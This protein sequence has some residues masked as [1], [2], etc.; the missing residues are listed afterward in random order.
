[1]ETKTIDTLHLVWYGEV[2]KDLPITIDMALCIPITDPACTPSVPNYGMVIDSPEFYA[3]SKRINQVESGLSYNLI[4]HTDVEQKLIMALP[5]N[6][7]EGL[8]LAKA[9]RL[10]PLL[11]PEYA[12]DLTDD[13][14]DIHACLKTYFLKTSLFQLVESDNFTSKMYLSAEQWAYLIYSNLLTHLTCK[15]ELHVVGEFTTNDCRPQLFRCQHFRTLHMYSKEL[16]AHCCDSFNNVLS[17]VRNFHDVIA[18]YCLKQ[19]FKDTIAL[20]SM[21]SDG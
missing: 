3:F 13:V 11:K 2:Y 17:L 16:R 21:L 7:R 6:A 15:G 12:K 10:T 19:N 8:K 9:I 5:Q 1:M 4:A 20:E 18:E 14:T